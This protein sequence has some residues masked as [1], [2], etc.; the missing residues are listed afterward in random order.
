VICLYENAS[1][2][3]LPAFRFHI[4]PQ[5]DTPPGDDQIR[6]LVR[7]AKRSGF[8]NTG[9]RTGDDDNFVFEFHGLLHPYFICIHLRS[10]VV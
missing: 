10:S 6:S 3:P 2:S 7:E 8:S 5:A 4:L 1:D 9:C